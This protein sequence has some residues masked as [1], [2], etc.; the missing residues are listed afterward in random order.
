MKMVRMLCSLVL[1]LAFAT[2]T[3]AQER[4]AS[5]R[6]EAATQV[7]GAYNAEGS[8]ENGSWVVVT[9]GR[10][11]LRGRDLFGS[12]DEYGQEFLR[13]APVWRIGADQSTRFM[14]ET[15]LVFQGERLP[16]G[17]YSIFADLA[18]DA[19]TLIF[20]NWG[21]KNDFREEN[22][23]ALWGAYGYTPDRDVLRTTMD[24]STIGMSADQLIITFT[25]MTQEGGV[26][27][28]WWDDQVATVPFEVAR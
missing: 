4:P 18:E 20:A 15:D 25:E 6:G 16:A 7:G 1:A 17:E 3:Q 23:D 19:W 27:T 2:T 12:G 13:G 28:I 24:V 10:P 22:P 5:P 8:F 26:F 11:I 9:Y 14:T 21:V